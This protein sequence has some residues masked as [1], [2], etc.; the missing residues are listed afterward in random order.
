MKIAVRV[1]RSFIT[2]LWQRYRGDPKVCGVIRKGL[3]LSNCHFLPKNGQ[4]GAYFDASWAI[5]SERNVQ[6]KTGMLIKYVLS[7]ALSSLHGQNFI[8]LRGL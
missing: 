4:L 1:L 2:K 3:A 6:S 7:I 5:K 8:K